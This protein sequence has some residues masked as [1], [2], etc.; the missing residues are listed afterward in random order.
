[1][2]MSQDRGAAYFGEAEI[3]KQAEFVTTIAMFE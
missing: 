1:M 2:K 3:R